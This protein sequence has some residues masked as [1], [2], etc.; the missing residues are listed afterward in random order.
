L[1]CIYNKCK[2]NH[3]NGVNWNMSVTQYMSRD[4]LYNYTIVE[5][6]YKKRNKSHDL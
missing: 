5:K 6:I 4:I 3:L 1:S 2:N